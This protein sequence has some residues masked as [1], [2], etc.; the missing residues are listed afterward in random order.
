MMEG[1][2]PHDRTQ[3]DRTS[4]KELLICY[5]LIAMSSF[6]LLSVSVN[7]ACQSI[8]FLLNLESGILAQ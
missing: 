5:P 4:Q 7:M 3:E 6:L 8:S 2:Y 1:A